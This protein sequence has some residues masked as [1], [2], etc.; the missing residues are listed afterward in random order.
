MEWIKD[1]I[2]WAAIAWALKEIYQLWKERGLSH[3][4]ALKANTEAIC[5][6]KLSL[7]TFEERLRQASELSEQVPK[8]QRD[9]DVAHTHIRIIAPHLYNR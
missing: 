4:A 5:E 6:L 3:T 1:P 8:M 7:T 2:A 9:L